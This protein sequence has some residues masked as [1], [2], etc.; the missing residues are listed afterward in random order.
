MPGLSSK[1]YKEVYEDWMRGENIATSVADGVSWLTT[2]D[3]G[4]TAGI[5][6]ADAEGPL[7][8][9]VLD[10]TDDDMGELA[11]HLVTFSGQNGQLSGE[12]RVKISAGAINSVAFNVGFNDDA[13]EDSNTLP[14]ELSTT[15]FTSNSATF[16][17]VVY[18]TDATNDDFHAFWVDDDTD[19]S[20][21]IA[22][23]RMTGLA[24]VADEWF[25]VRVVLS[26]RGSGKGM[27]AEITVCEES[28]NKTVQKRFN[29]NVDRDALLTFGIWME[30][31]ATVAHSFQVDHIH[32]MQSKATT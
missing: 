32:I 23:L 26:D 24:P 28:T 21:A 29:T 27:L 10:S 2:A 6:V 19:S 15:T 13:L 31:R 4:G 16:V 3:T 25:G 14:A 1:A 30:N 8:E 22:D 18:D 12:A 20:E 9:V 5:V 7:A 17:G 11:Y